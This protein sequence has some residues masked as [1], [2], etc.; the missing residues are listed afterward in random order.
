[1]K[2]GLLS[3]A[4]GAN[5]LDEVLGLAPTRPLG[6]TADRFML[7]FPSRDRFRAC[8]AL[9]LLL[10]GEALVRLDLEKRIAAYFVLSVAHC[11]NFRPGRSLLFHNPF[12][13]VLVKLVL[14]GET[15]AIERAAIHWILRSGFSAQVQSSI[16][17]ALIEF[18]GQAGTPAQDKQ[19]ATVSLSPQP[20]LRPWQDIGKNTSYVHQGGGNDSRRY[21]E[22]DPPLHRPPPPDIPIDPLDYKWIL[23]GPSGALGDGQGLGTSSE[24]GR[25]HFSGS[26]LFSKALQGPLLPSQQQELISEIQSQPEFTSQGSADP[27]SLPLVVENN[28]SVAVVLLKQVLGVGQLVEEYF[29][30]LVAMEMSFHSMEVVN[31]LI[32]ESEVPREITN[33]YITNCIS[34]IQTIKVRSQEQ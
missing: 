5:L 10:R 33:L 11:G 30:A 4:E 24:A 26:A 19:R 31:T 6:D 9:V 20:E 25:G 22:I 15:P 16:P 21:C 23:P 12:Y 1:M 13:H 3:A 29:S 27:S 32:S 2:A 34:N 7:S 18:A 14:D 28:P 8:S 17:A